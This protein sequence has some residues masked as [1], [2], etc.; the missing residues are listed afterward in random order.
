MPRF[1]KPTAPIWPRWR[2]IQD[3]QPS[4]GVAISTSEPHHLDPFI[5]DYTPHGEADNIH[6]F[7]GLNALVAPA[8]DGESWVFITREPTPGDQLQA[9]LDQLPQVEEQTFVNGE[10]GFVLYAIPPGDAFFEAFPPPTGQGVWVA[11]QAAF[12]PDDPEGIRTEL[13]L[14]VQFGDVAQL[15]G[16]ES[17]AVGQ[18]ASWYSIT[19]YWRVTRDVASPE[20]WAMF[21][22]VLDA[23]GN[24]VA[25]RDFLAVPASTWRA[26][27]VFI[28]THPVAM[29]E[30]VPPGLYHVEIGLYTQ[31][32]GSRFPIMVE[33][34]AVGDRLLF[35]PVEVGGE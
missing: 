9:I 18:A 22:H 23:E 3:H 28:Q 21:A 24:L 10:R 11:G 17:D 30:D 16:Y 34:E 26:G 35:E 1:S 15:V 20:P 14:P 7:D 4:G 32:D 2:P 19:L 13:A 25:G 29:P 5:F 8:G 27:D 33:G 6:W 31:A 12:P